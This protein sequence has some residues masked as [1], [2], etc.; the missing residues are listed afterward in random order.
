MVRDESDP[1][2]ELAQLDGE[3]D[4]LESVLAPDDCPQCVERVER[5]LEAAVRNRDDLLESFGRVVPI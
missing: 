1:E 2:I 3:I 4:A 5:L